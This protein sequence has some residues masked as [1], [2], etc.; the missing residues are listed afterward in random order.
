MYTCD[1]GHEGIAYN[2]DK[3]C[4]LCEARKEIMELERTVEGLEEEVSSL[5]EEV[6]ELQQSGE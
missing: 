2:N 1:Y 6:K 5:K 4:P 3:Y